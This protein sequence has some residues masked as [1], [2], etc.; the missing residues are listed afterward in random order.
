MVQ[1]RT[2]NVAFE[3][4]WPIQPYFF[5]SSTFIKEVHCIWCWLYQCYFFQLLFR[6][7]HFLFMVFGHFWRQSYKNSK[8]LDNLCLKCVQKKSRLTNCRFTTMSS[9][10]CAIYINI[11]HKTEVQAVILRCGMGLYLN[12]FKSY[13]TKYNF[14]LFRFSAIS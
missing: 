8:I 1:I 2:R 10:I 11:F 9:Q 6:S 4:Y 14:F 13:D 3:I 12:W 5:R 7:S